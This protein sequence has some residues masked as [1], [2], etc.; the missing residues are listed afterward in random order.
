MVN[1]LR[2][3]SKER[4]SLGAFDRRWN[5]VA[6]TPS[7][8]QAPLPSCFK[9]AGKRGFLLQPRWTVSGFRGATTLLSIWNLDVALRRALRCKVC[10]LPDQLST[11][12]SQSRDKRAV[13][14]KGSAA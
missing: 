14:K 12:R 13:D 3:R 9:L 10:T 6:S 5:V 7:T 8:D 1:G 11:W 4:R 2:D